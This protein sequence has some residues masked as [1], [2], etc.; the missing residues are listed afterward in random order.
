MSNV[1]S[2]KVFHLR[3][4]WFKINLSEFQLQVIRIF[5]A[6]IKNI[7][8][9]LKLRLNRIQVFHEELESNNE[10]RQLS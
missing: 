7:Y 10:P 6:V 2:R 9:C 1:T 3:Q 4:F 8:F 5:V